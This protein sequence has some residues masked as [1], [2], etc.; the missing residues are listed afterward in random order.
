MGI[1]TF[2]IYFGKIKKILDSIDE[3]CEDIEH[4]NRISILEEKPNPE[5]DDTIQQIK[6]MKMK[7]EDDREV[8]KKEVIAFLYK[9]SI[10]FL[11]TDKID[12]AD[13]LASEKFLNNLF[14]TYHHRH[15]VHHSHVTG[16]IT[17]HAHEYCNHK[18]KEFFYIIPVIAHNQFRFDFFLFLKRLRPSV[19]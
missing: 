6:N 9:K 5:L 7:G 3:F 14:F 19:W 8:T 18:V 15:D 16:K 11:P 1:S 4:E 12:T 13:F 10:N 2:D 17:G